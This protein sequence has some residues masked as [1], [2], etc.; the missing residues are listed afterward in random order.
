MDSTIDIKEYLKHNT[1]QLEKKHISNRFNFIDYNIFE[2]FVLERYSLHHLETHNYIKF[3]KVA[4]QINRCKYENEFLFHT[5]N[6]Q[7][8]ID[9]L[10][11]NQL[12]PRVN[13]NRYLFRLEKLLKI[14][15]Y[16]GMIITKTYHNVQKVIR[17]K[18]HLFYELCDKKDSKSSMKLIQ[19]ISC[20]NGLAFKHKLYSRI[21]KRLK[22]AIYQF[23]QWEKDH[24]I[25]HEKIR[26]CNLHRHYLGKKSEFIAKEC[27][28]KFIN[29]SNIKMF[30]KNC[31]KPFFVY[32]TNVNLLKIF[33]VPLQLTDKMKGE[34]DGVCFQ[35]NE[36]EDVYFLKYIIEVKSSVKATFEDVNKF[37]YMQK[38]LQNKEHNI[39][40]YEELRIN[41]FSFDYFLQEP[42]HKWCIY[43]CVVNPEEIIIEK[44]HFY[45]AKL[46]KVVDT[47]FI[48]EFY[49]S[50][51]TMIIKDKHKE[52]IVFEKRVTDLF[53]KWVEITGLIENDSCVFCIETCEKRDFEQYS[54][55]FPE[56]QIA[57]NKYNT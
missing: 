31:S 38:Y 51:K 3:V 2:K 52:L 7:S 37:L 55:S 12:Y 45:F 30:K 50:N 53:E 22:E 32:K 40:F 9:I 34:V 15:D 39:E 5:N 49:S 11:T 10:V 1:K 18:I 46:F 44:S 48:K 36:K 57:L 24:H 26:M 27:I 14:I 56:K 13:I 19:W 29:E 33:G 43:L 6:I 4:R 28:Q 23:E 35:Y 8:L 21:S 16:K 17:H 41:E 47:R 20:I 42:I 54:F 25:D